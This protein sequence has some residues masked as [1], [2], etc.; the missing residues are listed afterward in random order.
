MNIPIIGQTCA[1]DVKKVLDSQLPILVTQCE[2]RSKKF[3]KSAVFGVQVGAHLIEIVGRR[4]FLD[5][6]TG[7]NRFNKSNNRFDCP[8]LFGALSITFLSIVPKFI[9]APGPLK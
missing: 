9:V 5:R 2:K 8:Y 4:E 3:L 6:M 1:I 7:L